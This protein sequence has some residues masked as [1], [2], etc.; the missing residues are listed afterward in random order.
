M[1][2]K[3]ECNRINVFPV[4][5]GDTGTNMVL[6]VAGG[7]RSFGEDPPASS[8]TD[9]AEGFGSR[10]VLSAQ[11]N[12]GTILSFFFTQLAQELADNGRQSELTLDEF[13]TRIG[14]VGSNMMKAMPDAVPGT[15]I[16][17]VQESAEAL[18]KAESST[19]ST[20]TDMI[21]VWVKAANESLQ[22]TPDQLCVDGKYV[23]KAAGVVDSGAK[24]FFWL[25]EGMQ[26]GLAGNLTYGDYFVSSTDPNA[27]EDAIKGAAV[28]PHAGCGHAELKYRFCT[29]CVVEMKAG[30]TSDDLNN[31]VKH[32]GD[33]VVPVVSG[34]SQRAALGKLHIHT[35]EPEKVFEAVRAA[36]ITRDN[37]LLKEKV[38][39]MAEQVKV[40]GHAPSTYKVPDM[41][42]SKMA[43]LYL[44]SAD[45]PE[46]FRNEFERW[47]VPLK[48]VIDDVSYDDRV[49]MTPGSMFNVQRIKAYSEMS[50]GGAPPIN[51][52][53]KLKQ[54]LET[55]KDVL[56]VCLPRE[57]SRGN[58][59]G[60]TAGIESLSAEQQKR[61]SVFQAKWAAVHE[62]A[63][64]M[65]AYELAAAGHTVKDV[66]GDLAIYEEQY[67][68]TT[69]VIRDVYYGR[70]T[71]RLN[72]VLPKF[73]L[74]IIQKKK[75]QIAM[76][77]EFKKFKKDGSPKPDIAALTAKPDKLREKVVKYFGKHAASHK[78]N[79]QFDITL[80]HSARPDAM[81]PFEKE[82]RKAVPNIRHVH[83]CVMGG[84]I[85]VHFGPG[86]CGFELSPVVPN[87]L[88]Q[89]SVAKQEAQKGAVE[90]REVESEVGESGATYDL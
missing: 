67:S 22:R 3:D 77:Y 6:A 57:L 66:M 28:D 75:L 33:S 44:T 31:L 80:A 38:D 12:S 84:C 89:G 25:V 46:A 24:G 32:L 40:Q 55:G 51:Y 8:I 2:N 64:V 11:G 79:M 34:L 85:G 71:G 16:S 1:Q 60:L 69:A 4:P 63:M 18:A 49:E 70:K 7:V 37:I 30:S 65:R 29:E 45:V 87:L 86:G 42:D 15:M 68:V 50:T 58:W 10:V 62:G 76:G 59:A 88:G 81:V 43:I 20:V 23:L 74:D 26:K 54:A 90:L 35:N 36:S 73:A 14:T 56:V 21:D 78:G 48:L 27:V 39:D 53:T 41:A 9:C 13:R 47:Q 19:C 72:A 17:V 83:Y 52:E 61:V 5:D 82:L